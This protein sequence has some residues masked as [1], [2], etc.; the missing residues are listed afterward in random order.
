MTLNIEAET[1][2]ERF[3]GSFGLRTFE[4]M[5]GHSPRSAEA[6]FVYLGARDFKTQGL[7]LA[8]VTLLRSTRQRG[9][10]HSA[11]PG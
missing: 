7:F 9:P 2:E 5:D 10:L 8:H 11:S 6:L 4:I 3:G 1:L